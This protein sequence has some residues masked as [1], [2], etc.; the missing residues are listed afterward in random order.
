MVVIRL[1]LMMELTRFSSSTLEMCVAFQNLV[2]TLLGICRLRQSVSTGRPFS[3]DA[4]C[5]GADPV[6][7]G[8]EALINPK[9]PFSL[10]KSL[11]GR[12]ADGVAG[13]GVFIA[14][15]FGRVG[16]KSGM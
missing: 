14:V 5:S 2:R 1:A 6:R 10:L 9:T 3:I 7:G 15:L 8:L 4:L 11:G 12:R 13:Q 16:R